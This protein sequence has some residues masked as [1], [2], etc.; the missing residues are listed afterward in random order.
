LAVELFKQISGFEKIK[1]YTQIYERCGLLTSRTIF[2]HG[3]YLSDEEW[4]MLAR[5]RSA[6]L[7]AT[8]CGY[9]RARD[10]G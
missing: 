9:G 6:I 7:Y 5:H 8:T 10:Q 2:G 3:I 4:Q 1:N